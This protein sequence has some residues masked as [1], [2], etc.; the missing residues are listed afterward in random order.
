MLFPGSFNV[1]QVFELRLHHAGFRP[2]ATP[3]KRIAEKVS[4]LSDN[5]F[6]RALSE[7][8]KRLGHQPSPD[9]APL[10]QGE[11]QSVCAGIDWPDTEQWVPIKQQI[12]R[13]RFLLD[14]L[15]TA[16]KQGSHLARPFFLP[17]SRDV[18][19]VQRGAKQPDSVDPKRLAACLARIDRRCR[20]LEA[21]LSA[22]TIA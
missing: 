7:T 21:V 1:R 14:E 6:H 2:F 19:A 3:T 13:A 15:R 17:L 5:G 4:I 22:E 8:R 16:A 10:G 18:L 11:R 9:P 20:A 12:E